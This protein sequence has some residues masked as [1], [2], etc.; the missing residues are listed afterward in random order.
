[1]QLPPQMLQEDVALFSLLEEQLELQE[2]GECAL[3][4]AC[5]RQMRKL[6]LPAGPREK[7][8]Q[9]RLLLMLQKEK[10]LEQQLPPLLPQVWMNT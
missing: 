7:Q 2:D 10:Q 5:R 1:M 6:P 9:V 8:L 4:K 3:W